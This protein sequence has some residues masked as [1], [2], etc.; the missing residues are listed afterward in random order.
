LWW[1]SL[2]LLAV[3]VMAL[4]LA[5]GPRVLPEFR[6]PGAGRLDPVSAAVLL[7]A[8]LAAIFGIKEIAQNGISWLA[9]SSILAGLA[10]GV[11]FARRQLT[12]ADPTID[13]RLFR[14]AAFNA[15]LVTNLR[16][17]HRYS[18]RRPT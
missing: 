5:L 10:A 17:W 1:G 2:F 6:A 13:L 9:V 4:L 12:L 7:V 3:P 8:V 16:G 15:S 14:I 11:G 18:R